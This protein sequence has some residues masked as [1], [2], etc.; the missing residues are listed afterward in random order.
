[1]QKQN[2]KMQKTK[3]IRNRKSI[4]K[5]NSNSNSNSK[6]KSKIKNKKQKSKCQSTK[7]S[8]KLN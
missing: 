1:M 5:R 2:I 7:Q 6:R 3:G 4:S 8:A